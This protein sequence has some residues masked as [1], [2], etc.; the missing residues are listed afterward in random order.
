MSHVNLDLIFKYKLEEVE[1]LKAD[2]S[3]RDFRV[4]WGTFVIWVFPIDGSMQQ[5]YWA[6]YQEF[7]NHNPTEADLF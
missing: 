4:N 2:G 6:P 1:G 3:I 7:E 5:L